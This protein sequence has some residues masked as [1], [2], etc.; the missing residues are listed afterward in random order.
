MQNMD[1][2]QVKKEIKPTDMIRIADKVDV[3]Y[4]Y[5]RMIFDGERK[6]NKK[7]GLQVIRESIKLAELNREFMSNKTI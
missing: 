3:S 5:V 7:K 4:R 1:I 6:P 2:S